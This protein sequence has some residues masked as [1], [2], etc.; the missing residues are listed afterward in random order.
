MAATAEQKGHHKFDWVH[1]KADGS[2]FYAA[3]MLTSIVLH[4]RRLLHATVRDITYRKQAE[5]ALFEQYELQRVL[6]STIPA[7]VYVKD[8][9]SVFMAANKNFG[10]LV[11]MPE[12]EIP[13]KTDY[14]LFPEPVAD[15]FRKKAWKSS[16]PASRC[17]IS[18]RT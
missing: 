15:A 1:R 14:D 9:D 17:S 4:G 12:N 13:G 5:K 16:R 18:N 8:K 11:G 6:L 3:I 2:D 10:A 7:Y